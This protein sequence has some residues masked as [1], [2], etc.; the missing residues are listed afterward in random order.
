MCSTLLLLALAAVAVPAV[1]ILTGRWRLLPILSGSMAPGIPAGSLVLVTPSPPQRIRVGD[2]VVYKIPIADHRLIAHRVVAV[3]ARGRR[4]LIETKGDANA[5]LDPW[6]A[7]LQGEKAWLVRAEVPLLGYPA[8][9]A[10]RA[11]RF[12]LLAGAVF[13]LVA[14]AI[15]RIWSDS[16][17]TEG[18]GGTHVAPRP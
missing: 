14:A 2:V 16:S 7:R 4:P 12:L 3:L 15:R 5:R 10:K 17:H 13:L 8:L 6:H 1:G 18:A 9:F 11:W